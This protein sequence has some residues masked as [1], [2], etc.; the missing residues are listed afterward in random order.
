M[1][2]ISILIDKRHLDLQEVGYNTEKAP[3]FLCEHCGVILSSKQSLKHHMDMKHSE[4]VTTYQC[5]KCL[6]TCNRLDNI[7]RHIRKHPDKTNTPKIV[8]YEIKPLHLLLSVC[9]VS[10]GAKAKEMKT[11]SQNKNTLNYKTIF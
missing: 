1:E 3:E 10:P 9:S 11:N 2:R 5:S 8:M 7:R 6:T 4:K